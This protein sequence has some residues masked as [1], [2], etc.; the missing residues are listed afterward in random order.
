VA[1]LAK[2]PRQ[3]LAHIPGYREPGVPG[4]FAPDRYF[5]SF[6]V[7]V[8]QLQMCHFSGP[9]AEPRQEEKDRIIA[10]AQRG[11]LRARLEQALNMLRFKELREL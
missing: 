2:I 11:I 6:P 8:V 4:T 3:S 9:Q 10:L 7:D 5:S 1:A